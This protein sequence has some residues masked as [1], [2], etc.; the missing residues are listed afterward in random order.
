[1]ATKEQLRELVDQMPAADRRGMLTENIDKERIDTIAAQIAQGGKENILLLIAMLGPPGSEE[2]VKPQFALHA[3][4]NH[5]LVIRDEKLRQEIAAAIA[6]QLGNKELHPYNRNVLCQELQWAGRDEACPALGAVLLDDDV[7]DAAASALVA[8]GGERAAAQLRTATAAAKGKARLNVIDALAALADVKSADTFRK[9]IADD[10][11][12]VR[13]AAVAGLARLGLAD[14][15][16]P[17]L[18][19]A[20]KAAGWERSQ[21][22]KSCLVLAEKLAARGD[23]SAA[24]SIY[25]QLKNNRTGKLES[26]V[27][28]AADRGLA[29]I[30]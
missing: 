6:G 8:I 5:P 9:A 1:M 27:R 18:A 24:R 22:T 21:L 17:L 29:A 16:Q 12:E 25:E 7:T 26:H 20:D 13:L 11:R 15:A 19:A 14:T 3:A 4:V 30:V 23:K 10:D 28:D 2:N